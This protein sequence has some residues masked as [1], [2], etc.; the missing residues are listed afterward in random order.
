MMKAVLFSVLLV[1]TIW[2]PLGGDDGCAWDCQ[3]E[4]DDAVRECG[5]LDYPESSECYRLARRR[6][7]RCL[8]ACER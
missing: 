7:E 2:Q 6:F 1:L 3:L 5:Q 4:F 8:R